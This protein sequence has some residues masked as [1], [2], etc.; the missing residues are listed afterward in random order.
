MAQGP[1]A[2]ARSQKS[3]GGPSHPIEMSPMTKYDKKS[4]LFQF[5]F[6]LAF[7]ASNIVIN[8]NIENHTGAPSTPQ[9][10]FCQPI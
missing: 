8:N 9:F 1:I 5:W 10:N 3:P 2:L 6:L 7:F 4:I